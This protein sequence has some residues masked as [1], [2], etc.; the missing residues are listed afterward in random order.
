LQIK[1]KTHN[2]I[3]DRAQVRIG[4][5]QGDGKR[6]FHRNIFT[7]SGKIHGLALV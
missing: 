4:F 3:T 2:Y 1:E 5:V 6:G 7:C